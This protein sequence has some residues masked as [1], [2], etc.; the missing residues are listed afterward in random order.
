[1]SSVSVSARGTWARDL[2]WVCERGHSV[3]FGKIS[4]V[5]GGG[6][7]NR[8]ICLQCNVM[9]GKCACKNRRELSVEEM[10]LPVPKKEKIS[11]EEFFQTMR[12]YAIACIVE[13]G[14]LLI[15][16]KQSLKAILMCLG[17]RFPDYN[18]IIA[19]IEA[20]GLALRQWQVTPIQVGAAEKYHLTNLQ[21][22]CL[23]NEKGQ[24]RTF[25][26][27]KQAVLTMQAEN[28]AVA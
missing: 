4:A 7:M 15:D 23:L 17:Y 3:D 1:M 20:E 22:Q 6:V 13:D 27:F 2:S 5:K 21:G 10:A 14:E 9:G 25:A 24:P 16:D 19:Q 8:T 28:K 11:P 26:D 12:V 18:T